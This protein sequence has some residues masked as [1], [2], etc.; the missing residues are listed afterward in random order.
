ML[1]RAGNET[2]KEFEGVHA[3][4]AKAVELKFFFGY[5]HGEVAAMTGLWR[6]T[7]DPRPGVRPSLDLRTDS[8]CHQEQRHGRSHGTTALSRTRSSMDE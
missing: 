3:R 6:R 8:R 4:A 5:S 1:A 7:G 2:L